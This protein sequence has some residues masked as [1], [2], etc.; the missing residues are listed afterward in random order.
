MYKYVLSELMK[1][2][3]SYSA[4]V[5]ARFK[6]NNKNEN[7]Y[8]ELLQELMLLNILAISGKSNNCKFQ[9]LGYILEIF[10]SAKSMVR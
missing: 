7:E 9:F 6:Y 3:F 1:E 2:I 8:K 10:R 5:F 4:S